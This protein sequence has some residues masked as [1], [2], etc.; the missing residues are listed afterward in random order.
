MAAHPPGDRARGAVCLEE[1]RRVGQQQQVRLR[2]GAAGGI[3]RAGAAAPPCGSQLLHVEGGR[4]HRVRQ[5]RHFALCARQ[6]RAPALPLANLRPHR[7]AGTLHG[8]L[9]FKKLTSPLQC[10]LFLPSLQDKD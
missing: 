6:V 4:Q 2:H 3:V 9:S 10:M 8:Q 7:S 1:Q 5:L